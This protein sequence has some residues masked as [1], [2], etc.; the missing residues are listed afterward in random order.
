MLGQLRKKG[1]AYPRDDTDVRDA[2]K[3][4]KAAIHAGQGLLLTVEELSADDYD[5][6]RLDMEEKYYETFGKD[7]FRRGGKF[8]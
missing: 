1:H 7:P 2:E 6:H 3:V 5:E 4:V 8:Y